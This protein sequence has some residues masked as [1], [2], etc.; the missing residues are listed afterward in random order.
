MALSRFILL[1]FLCSCMSLSYGQKILIGLVVKIADGDTMTLLD[2]NKKQYR[3]RLHGI[4]CP[5]RKQ[6]FSKQATEHL[7]SYCF[8]KNVKVE[9]LD[10]DRYGRLIGKVWAGGVDVGLSLLQHGLAW[11][12]KYFDSSEQYAKAEQQAKRKKIGL[13]SM[14]NPTAPW[15]FRRKK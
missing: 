10:K 12:Y 6:D 2:A 11:H 8:N 9:V 4:D 1:L 5:E 7:S 3:I 15:D 13:W 14:K